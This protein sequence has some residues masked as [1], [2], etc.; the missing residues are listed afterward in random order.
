[1]WTKLWNK[2][3]LG[4]WPL[5]K[6]KQRADTDGCHCSAHVQDRGAGADAVLHGVITGVALAPHNHLTDRS[7]C[8]AFS[9]QGLQQCIRVSTVQIMQNIHSSIYCMP[10]L[11]WQLMFQDFRVLQASQRSHGVADPSLWDLNYLNVLVQTGT[12]PAQRPGI[13]QDTLL[14]SGNQFWP[15]E[16]LSVTSSLRGSCTCPR[17]YYT[18]MGTSPAL[19]FPLYHSCSGKRLTRQEGLIV[20]IPCVRNDT[21]LEGLGVH[22]QAARARIP[23]NTESGQLR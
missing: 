8:K 13:V 20:T 3:P 18:R 7:N 11:H 9:L 22:W 19:A 15:R 5:G 17:Q 23:D 16:S 21:S 14:Y 10:H 2:A 4:D 12:A 1:M 6:V